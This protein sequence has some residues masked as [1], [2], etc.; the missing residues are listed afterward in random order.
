MSTR[1][2]QDVSLAANL[3]IARTDFRRRKDTIYVLLGGRSEV[4]GRGNT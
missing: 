4:V 2:R 3:V 1:E